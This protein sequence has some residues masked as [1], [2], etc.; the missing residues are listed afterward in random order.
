VTTTIAVVRAEAYYT[1]P[2]RQPANSFDSIPV[3]ERVF[4]WLSYR[5]GRRLSPPDGPVDQTY[6]ARINQNRW[7]ADCICG[8]A[9][10]V[11][12]TDPRSACT[13]CGW[14]WCTLLFPDDVDAVEAAL[15]SLPPYL[16]NWWNDAD[17]RNPNPPITDPQPPGPLATT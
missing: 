1:P 8:A 11:S 10:I 3:A 4:A 13:E 9:Q 12:P 2:P 5:L 15:M 16:R 14:G 7:L 17:P 6:Y